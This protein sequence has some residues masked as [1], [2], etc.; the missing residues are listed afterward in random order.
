M[1]SEGDSH[2]QGNELKEDKG[3]GGKGQDGGGSMATYDKG[4]TSSGCLP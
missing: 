1:R 3:E 2:I 4:N